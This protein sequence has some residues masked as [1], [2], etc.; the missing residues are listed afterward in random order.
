M[1]S[2][3][4][5]VV[6][7]FMK[8]QKQNPFEH[9]RVIFQRHGGVLRT[10]DALFAGIHPETFYAMRDSGVIERMSRGLYRLADLPKLGQPDLVTAALKIPKGVVCLISALSFHG[11]T[12]Q[13]PHEI[14]CALPRGAKKPKV[15]FPPVRIFWFIEDVFR[16]GI[17]THR[18]EGTDLRVYSEEKT[19]ADCF[20]YRNK[21]GLDTALEALRLYR[22]RKKTNANKL[23][24]YARLC[25]VQN[26]MQPYL[27]A[28]L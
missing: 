3:G 10:R 16:E 11:I 2:A 12:T 20:K 21:I 25:R 22:Q 8:T 18:V 23:M 6:D 4:F 19:L 5:F 27:E 15:D 1:I 14:Y 9:A 13:I 7:N 24:K 28:I 17:E 26:I